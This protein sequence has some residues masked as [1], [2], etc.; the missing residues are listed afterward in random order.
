MQF[1][2]ADYWCNR[3]HEKSQ[4]RRLLN[5]LRQQEQRDLFVEA[6]NERQERALAKS[7]RKRKRSAA[8]FPTPESMSR[9]R[10]RSDEVRK[11]IETIDDSDDD[12]FVRN[13]RQLSDPFQ[14]NDFEHESCGDNEDELDQSQLKKIRRE[15]VEHVK[16]NTPSSVLLRSFLLLQR[17][18]C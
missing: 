6:E 13:S 1:E 2:T 7:E 11:S 16:K 14:T 4:N 18:P 3:I 9:K 15:N 17:S 5:E 10:R 8:A 12:L